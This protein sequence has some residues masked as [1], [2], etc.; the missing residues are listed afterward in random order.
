MTQHRTAA[1]AAIAAAGLV[2]GAYYGNAW[3]IEKELGRGLAQHQR[4]AAE[5]AKT[6]ESPQDLLAWYD[7]N[8]AAV[9]ALTD[10]NRKYAVPP[11]RAMLDLT[12]AVT[13]KL[14]EFLRGVL[15]ASVAVEEITTPSP[16][17]V[18]QREDYADVRA[19]LEAAATA[20]ERAPVDFEAR[21]EQIRDLIGAS[22]ASEATRVKLWQMAQHTFTTSAPQFERLPERARTLRPYLEVLDF[23]HA[24]RAEYVV[25]D[26]GKIVFDSMVTHAQ[27]QR[28]VEAA[29]QKARR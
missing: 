28:A 10:R 22:D 17:L 11:A 19:R 29:Q 8:S 21:R 27:F 24:R 2:V 3:W 25:N 1:V 16:G 12:E 4:R 7:A 15:A 5:T 14:D 20:F 6:V 18:A 13:R 26:E 9:Y 23:L